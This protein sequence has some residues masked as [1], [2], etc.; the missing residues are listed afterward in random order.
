MLT[1][2]L[3]AVR[4]VVFASG[5]GA[6]RRQ[7][8]DVGQRFQSTHGFDDCRRFCCRPTGGFGSI[9]NTGLGI[10]ASVS[11]PLVGWLVD[12][13]DS[14]QPVFA[15]SILFLLLGPIATRWIR[16]DRPYLGE[17]VTGPEPT[18]ATATARVA[19]L[20]ESLQTGKS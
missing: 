20:D 4:A 6:Q 12:R 15:L 1:V 7:F 8:M 10:A 13:T 5:T 18:S 17:P 3:A 9:M 16:P 19:R 11:P 2:A 14:W